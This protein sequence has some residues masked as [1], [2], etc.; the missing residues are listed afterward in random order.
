MTDELLLSLCLT[1][2]KNFIGEV[3]MP[4]YF[5]VLNM[6]DYMVRSCIL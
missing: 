6:H 5:A 2:M 1:S 4:V 3:D